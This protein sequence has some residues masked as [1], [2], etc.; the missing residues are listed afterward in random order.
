MR[1]DRARSSYV[2][3]ALGALMDPGFL[4][5]AVTDGGCAG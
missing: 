2:P 1:D 4:R 3:T 5:R